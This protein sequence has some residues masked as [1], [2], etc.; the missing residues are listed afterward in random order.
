MQGMLSS[1]LVHC[2]FPI[3]KM[4]NHIQPTTRGRGLA[5][6]FIL[7]NMAPVFTPLDDLD[8]LL[9]KIQGVNAQIKGVRIPHVR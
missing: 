2:T 4:F 5:R 1:K 3:L 8:E 6:P 7:P 9:E